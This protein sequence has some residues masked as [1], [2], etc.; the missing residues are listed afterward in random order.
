MSEQMAIV[1]ETGENGVARILTDRKGGCG[2]CHSGA[3]GCRSCLT[4]ARMESRAANPLG[5]RAGD[6]VKVHIASKEVFKGA[7]ALYLTPVVAL[8]AGAIGG[9]WFGGRAGWPSSIGAVVGSLI[10][11]LIAA[12]AIILLDRSSYARRRLQPTITGIVTARSHTG[13]ISPNRCCG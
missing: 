6:L 3:G 2:G 5:A 10:G 7:A 13:P 9:D 4:G 8:L 12:V 1:I 11:L